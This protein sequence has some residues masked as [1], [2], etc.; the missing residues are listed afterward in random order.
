MKTAHTTL[1][2]LLLFVTLSAEKCTKSTAMDT[3]ILGSRWNLETLA[4]KPYQLPDGVEKPYIQVAA[5]GALSG[6]NGCNRLMGSVKAD[7]D[8]VEF[9]GLG[10]T[11]KMCPAAQEVERSFMDAL[12][13][14][15]HYHIKGDQLTLEGDAGALATLTKGK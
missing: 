8:A 5:D 7:G 13:N 4:G 2:A 12:R 3:S 10:S 11:K 6:F 1:A 9:P 15:K 14:T